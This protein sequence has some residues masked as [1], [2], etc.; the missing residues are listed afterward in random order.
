MF[1]FGRVATR[2][3]NSS[4]HSFLIHTSGAGILHPV[5]KSIHEFSLNSHPA[6]SGYIILNCCS[7]SLS[8]CLVVSNGENGENNLGFRVIVSLLGDPCIL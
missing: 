6:A 8:F 3:G 5:F 7:S 2:G 1:F 4:N